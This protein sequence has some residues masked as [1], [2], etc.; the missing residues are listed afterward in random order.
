M[1][2]AQTNMQ[3]PKHLPNEHADEL[4]ELTGRRFSKNEI[5]VWYEGFKKDCG[6]NGY[7]SF[8][9]FESL[10][11]TP[12]NKMNSR[13]VLRVTKEWDKNQEGWALDTFQPRKD[14]LLNF[15]EFVLAYSKLQELQC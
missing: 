9:D 3:L 4:S 13:T 2:Q 12:E 11:L 7:M 1:G 5:E 8:K 6:V 15:D 10:Q 14:D